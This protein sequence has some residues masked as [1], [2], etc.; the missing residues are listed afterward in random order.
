MDHPFVV[1]STYANGLGEYTVQQI[2]PPHMRVRYANGEEAT[3]ELALQAR[4][5]ARLCAE[6]EEA[7]AP[8]PTRRPARRRRSGSTSKQ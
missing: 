5:W 1:G 2:R 7:A 3:L 4:I 6:A 8:K